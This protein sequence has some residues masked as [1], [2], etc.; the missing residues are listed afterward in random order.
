MSEMIEKLFWRVEFGE[1]GEK[2]FIRRQSGELLFTLRPLYEFALQIDCGEYCGLVDSGDCEREERFADHQYRICWKHPLFTLESVYS[3][4]EDSVIKNMTLTA[5]KRLFLRYAQTE[6]SDCDA[7]LSGG[8]EGQPV[9]L[10]GEGFVSMI[11]PAAQNYFSGERLRLEQ[12]PYIALEEGET[13]AFFPIV[14]GFRTEETLEESFRQYILGHK[15]KTPAGVR[16]YGD[17]GAHDELA[18]E[19]ELSESL[20]FEMLSRLERGRERGVFFDYYLMDAFWFDKT[21]G[22]RKFLDKNWPD[23]P[24]SFLKALNCRGMKFGLWFDVNMGHMTLPEKE[25]GEY[26]CLAYRENVETLF[27][28]IRRQMADCGCSMLKLDFAFFGCDKR[29]HGDAHAPDYTASKEPAIRMFIEE[30]VRLYRDYPGLLVTGYNGFT[31]NLSCL[32]QVGPCEKTG[33]ISPWW[34]LYLDYLYCGDP[35]PS[36]LPARDL[37]NSLLWYTDAMIEKFDQS[38]MPL[39]AIDDHGTMVGDTNTIY[40]LG[41]GNFR[42]SW[43]MNLSRGSRREMLYGALDCL[44]EEDWDFLAQSQDFFDFVCRDD[45]RTK[46]VGG[47]PARGQV[48][49]YSN[50]GADRGYVT[51]VNPDRK[52]AFFSLTERRIGRRSMEIRRIY[53][54]KRFVDEVLSRSGKTVGIW[55]EPCE[56]TVLFWEERKDEAERGGYL[57]LCPG[58][59]ETIALSGGCRFFML[60]LTDRKGFPLRIFG[61]EEAP[62]GIMTPDMGLVVEQVHG[63]RI[64]S[65]CSWMEYGIGGERKGR[66]RIRIELHS[67]REEC[68][69]VEWQER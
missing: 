45:V 31:T 44:E 3:M 6:V 23:G 32:G 33:V 60:K 69:Y 59:H 35:R 61:G 21:A 46:R 53:G 5:E 1:D 17:W 8:G 55:L 56:V 36:E 20:A 30:L 38:L 34:C 54:N 67:C 43:I 15:K 7:E 24:E 19:E 49:G 10:G 29:E 63:Q 50:N 65:G 51:L 62:V 41:K 2:R 58:G 16:I 18:G 12:A 39:S 11:F 13:F 26:A 14:Y 28:G 37:G 64:W 40:Y 47:S 66:D 42:D 57:T 22:Y 52:R 9:F 27:Q 4:E 25:A 68:L 48:Y